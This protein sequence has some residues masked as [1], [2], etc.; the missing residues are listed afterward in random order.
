MIVSAHALK[1]RGSGAA[2]VD[3]ELRRGVERRSLPDKL[4]AKNDGLQA[5]KHTT[6]TTHN[7]QQ[8]AH[9]ARLCCSGPYTLEVEFN[10]AP[11]TTT[12]TWQR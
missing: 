9:R 5:Q 4:Q 1:T 11:A 10:S 12:T 3:K 2:Q 6:H 7:T 8:G